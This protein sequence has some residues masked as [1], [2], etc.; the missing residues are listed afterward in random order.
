MSASPALRITY[1][2]FVADCLETLEEVGLRARDPWKRLGG[3][4]LALVP[5]L[6]AED[7]WADAVIELVRRQ[8]ALPP[9]GSASTRR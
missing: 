7:G 2:P 3:D 5:S 4:S 6:N 9:A 8:A 1:E